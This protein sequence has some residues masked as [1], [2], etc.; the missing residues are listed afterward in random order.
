M[1][2]LLFL[3]LIVSVGFTQVSLAQENPLWTKGQYFGGYPSLDKYL[4]QGI[5]FKISP[6]KITMKDININ[7]PAEC[8]DEENN[9]SER[10]THFSQTEIEPLT[11]TRTDRQQSLYFAYLDSFDRNWNTELRIRWSRDRQ[12]FRVSLHTLSD[13]LE[14]TYC[15]ADVIL[16]RGARKGRA[17]SL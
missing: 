9:V 12:R 11:M 7:F 14:D 13:T 4:E 6:D 5:S 1:R 2:T 10:N 3:L 16:A 8:Y 15:K 17:P